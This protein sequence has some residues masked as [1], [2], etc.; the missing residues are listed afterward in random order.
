M[1]G[2]ASY[3]HAIV[4]ESCTIKVASL[5]SQPIPYSST[6][7]VPRSVMIDA[8]IEEVIVKMMAYQ[9]QFF[10]ASVQVCSLGIVL[11]VMK[12]YSVIYH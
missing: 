10:D 4:V 2:V 9:V 1:C 6:Y 3:L 5:L 11:Q 8:I 12:V 7:G